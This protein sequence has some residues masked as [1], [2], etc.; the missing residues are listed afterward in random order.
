MEMQM[1]GFELV[2]I[3]NKHKGPVYVS[4]L[5]ADDTVPIEAKKKDLTA[6]ARN[7]K[8]QECGVSARVH[9]DNHWPIL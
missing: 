1:T 7:Y 8:T 5:T 9:E 4:M 3:V 2:K 6:W